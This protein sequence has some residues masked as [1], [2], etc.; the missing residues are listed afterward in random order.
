MRPVLSALTFLAAT[1]LAGPF[2]GS[3][4]AEPVV[5]TGESTGGR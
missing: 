1:A 4:D 3:A 2:I 5:Y